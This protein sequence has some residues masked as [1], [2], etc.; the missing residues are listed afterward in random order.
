MKRQLPAIFYLL[1]GILF[2]V[3]SRRSPLRLRTHNQPSAQQ[4]NKIC[5]GANNRLGL[6]L[7]STFITS[8]SFWVEI[9][10]MNCCLLNAAKGL[11]R[12]YMIISLGERYF[13]LE[14]VFFTALLISCVEMLCKNI[15]FRWIIRVNMDENAAYSRLFVGFVLLLC[16]FV[17]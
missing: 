5:S 1:V 7:F 15:S 17:I 13:I 6:I 10:R 9:F 12:I 2:L 8:L 3:R 11:Y 14:V 4:S 16:D